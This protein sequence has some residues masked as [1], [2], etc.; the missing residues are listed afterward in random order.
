MLP[1]AD[2][3]STMLLALW[4][5]RRHQELLLDLGERKGWSEG[6]RAAATERLA[7]WLAA[8]LELPASLPAGPSHAQQE[9]LALSDLP[10]EGVEPVVGVGRHTVALAQLVGTAPKTLANTLKAGLRSDRRDHRWILFLSRLHRGETDDAAWVFH[11]R[12]PQAVAT[13]LARRTSAPQLDAADALL[14]LSLVAL[15]QRRRRSGEGRSARGI[16][17][18]RRLLP[19][20]VSALDCWVLAP[21][22]L[23]PL[24]ALGVRL[25]NDAG[26]ALV[27]VALDAALTEAHLAPHR[28]RRTELTTT[29]SETALR[30]AE[31]ALRAADDVLGRA[32]VAELLGQPE[33]D[34]FRWRVSRMRAYPAGVPTPAPS[35]AVAEHPYV[36]LARAIDDARSSPER[37]KRFASHEPGYFML[38]PQARRL[39]LLEDR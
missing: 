13:A 9:L 11:R 8:E 6:D 5:S 14:V 3:L 16:E 4:P 29:S 7:A 1:L 39:G 24:A 31:S 36:R 20:P 37:P 22:Q 25:G 38:L 23:R 28:A 26:Q 15:W 34:V 19:K 18:A 32:D 2:I 12:S 21:S 35:V 27:A 17:T 10:V 30:L 33:I